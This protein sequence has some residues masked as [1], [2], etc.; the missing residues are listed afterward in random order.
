MSNLSGTWNVDPVHST[1]SFVVR[2]A[3]VTKVRGTFNEW[4][5]EITIDGENPAASTA[6]AT[7]KIDSVDTRNADRDKHLASDASLTP[8]TTR[9]QRLPPPASTSTSTAT[10]P[11]QAI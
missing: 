5:S 6:T 4:S 2:H 9:R 10:A 11:S 8:P 7:V 3:M 1:L